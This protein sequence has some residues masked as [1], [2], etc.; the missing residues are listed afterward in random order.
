MPVRSRKKK[1][2][3]QGTLEYVLDDLLE[4]KAEVDP[5]KAKSLKT[6]LLSQKD[7]NVSLSLVE[8]FRL[9]GQLVLIEKGETKLRRLVFFN[10]QKGSFQIKDIPA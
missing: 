6:Y 9:N 8:G 3:T 10:P 4:L 7:D 1:K 5:K 2:S